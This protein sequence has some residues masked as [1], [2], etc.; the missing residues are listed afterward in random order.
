MLTENTTSALRLLTLLVFGFGGDA[1]EAE[2]FGLAVVFTT[3]EA[4]TLDALD[5]AGAFIAFV[6]DADFL[7]VLAFVGVFLVTDP[8]LILLKALAAAPRVCL[9]ILL[10]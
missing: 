8:D 10:D 7:A 6:L 5:L 9:A 2:A 3:F 1:R 4:E